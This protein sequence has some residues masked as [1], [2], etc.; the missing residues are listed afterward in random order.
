M[1]TETSID[2]M[3]KE[4]ELLRQTIQEFEK[5]DISTL[6]LFSKAMDA[7][8]NLNRDETL[9]GRIDIGLRKQRLFLRDL[10][11]QLDVTH[12]DPARKRYDP[13]GWVTEAQTLEKGHEEGFYLDRTKSLLTFLEGI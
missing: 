13:N 7:W 4:L 11:G 2:I 8:E 6:D 12:G 1:E 5:K 3:S 9:R 10:Y